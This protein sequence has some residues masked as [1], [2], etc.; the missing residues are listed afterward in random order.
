MPGLSNVGRSRQ[1]LPFWV[2]WPGELGQKDGARSVSAMISGCEPERGPIMHVDAIVGVWRL[3][4]FQRRNGLTEVESRP[5]NGLLFYTTDGFMSAVISYR[6][7]GRFASQDY[8]G[9][10]PAEA[11]SAVDSYLSYCG[12]YTL[13]D[14]TVIHHV[15]MSMYPNWAGSDQRRSALL[16]DGQLVLGAPMFIDGEEWTYELVWRRPE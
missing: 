3:V 10:T 8:R 1:V 2:V 16:R 13:S 14:D 4:G 6:D 9:G 12:R 7:R 5:A 11:K 15:E